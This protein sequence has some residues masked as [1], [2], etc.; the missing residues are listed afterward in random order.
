M[1][2]N[3]YIELIKNINL[4]KFV[5]FFK[6]NLI[7]FKV[8]YSLNGKVIIILDVENEF[9]WKINLSDI[10][11][12]FSVNDINQNFLLF[13]AIENIL[14]CRKNYYIDINK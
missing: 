10:H 13:V 3:N 9:N 11:D 6:K 14:N 8:I 4:D 2:N 1:E 7:D 12:Y 5:S